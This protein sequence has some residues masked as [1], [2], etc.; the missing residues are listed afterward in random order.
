MA[1]DLRG[2]VREQLVEGKSDTEIKDY[3]VA[4]Y[5]EFVLLKPPVAPAT[6]LLWVGPFAILFMAA[7]W[8]WLRGRKSFDTSGEALLA[9]GDQQPLSAAERAELAK[10]VGE[11]DNR[12]NSPDQG[13]TDR[14]NR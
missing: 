9:T 10:I 5:G 12:P 6:Y 2:L 13:G 7:G 3:L 8:V 11:P 1:R 14:S 4:R